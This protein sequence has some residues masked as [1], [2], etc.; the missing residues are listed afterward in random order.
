[1]PHLQARKRGAPGDGRWTSSGSRPASSGGT[2]VSSEAAISFETLIAESPDEPIDELIEMGDLF[3]L[4]HFIQQDFQDVLTELRQAGFPFEDAWFA[5]HFEFR[6]PRCGSVAHAGLDLEL[7][8]A[9]EPW[10]VLGEEPGPG[11]TSRYVD[12]S[13]E[14]VQVKVRGLTDTRR[15]RPDRAGARSPA[16]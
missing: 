5:P 13:V 6:F 8:Q 16:A 2:N 12:S 15:L 9:L 14:R 3:M 11:A 1:M 4:P 7:R 10:H